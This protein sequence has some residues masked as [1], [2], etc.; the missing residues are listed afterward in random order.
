MS[1]QSILVVQKYVWKRCRRREARHPLTVDS[2]LLGRAVA[3]PADWVARQAAVPPPVLLPHWADGQRGVVSGEVVAFGRSQ[4]H[5][6]PQPLE[7]HPG[8][9]VDS[10][11]PGDVGRVLHHGLRRALLNHRHGHGD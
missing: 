4:R 11:G 10:A 1:V 8:P 7:V 6:V 3:P 2:E 5:V 9:P